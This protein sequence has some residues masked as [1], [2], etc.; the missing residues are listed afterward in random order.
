M[1]KVIFSAFVV[2]LLL[3]IAFVTCTVQ[4]GNNVF[5]KNGSVEIVLNGEISITDNVDFYLDGR[6]I[7]SFMSGNKIIDSLPVG[8]RT[9]KLYSST[10]SFSPDSFE[11]TIEENEKTA[12]YSTIQKIITGIVRVNEPADAMITINNLYRGLTPLDIKLP[13]G[14]YTV[15]LKKGNN[16]ANVICSVSVN[17]INE[18]Q[19]ASFVYTPAILLEHFSNVSCPPCPEADE[20]VQSTVTKIFSNKTLVPVCQISYSTNFPTR[21]DPFYLFDKVN[22]QAAFD[23]YYKAGL[24]LNV[25]AVLV[26]GDSITMTM[27]TLA[28]TL[29]SAIQKSFQKPAYCSMYFK[30]LTKTGG[31]VVIGNI[32]QSSDPVSLHITVVENVIELGASPGTNGQKT[33][34]YMYRRTFQDYKTAIPVAK[35]TMVNFSFE[36]ESSS[37]NTINFNNSLTFV[38]YL[39]NNKTKKVLETIFVKF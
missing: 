24:V 19:N 23:A 13:E 5:Q 1:A 21:D 16:I 11:L 15:E 32:P 36:N 31:S 28:N 2:T 20:I 38:S 33:F 30:N 17:K 27:L 18:V 4:M 39:Q 29:T 3:S 8:R 25:P 34:H 12:I 14:V 10:Y 7:T 9:V 37:A 35:D 22:Q 26:D 6:K